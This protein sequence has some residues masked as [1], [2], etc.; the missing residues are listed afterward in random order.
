MQ[1]FD[2]NVHVFYVNMSV[3]LCI[4][5]YTSKTTLISIDDAVLLLTYKNIAITC[6]LLRR[7]LLKL[8]VVCHPQPCLT[9]LQVNFTS[10]TQFIL[11]VHAK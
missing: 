2:H 3:N 10:Q 1:V 6:V 8:R 9:G 11:K 5:S 4:Q 7:T